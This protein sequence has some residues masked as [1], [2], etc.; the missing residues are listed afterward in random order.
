[1]S[2]VVTCHPVDVMLFLP[3]KKDKIRYVMTLG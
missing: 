2:L 3:F 1:M